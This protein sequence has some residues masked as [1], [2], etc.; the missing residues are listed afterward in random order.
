MINL[1]LVYYFEYLIC[2]GLPIAISGQI[3]EKYPDEKDGFIL[4]NSFVIFNFCYQFGVFISRSSL[5]IVKI[6]KV[7]I[8][9]LL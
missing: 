5:S 2:T 8:L 6:E 9:T 3:K 7:W 1:S 4:T